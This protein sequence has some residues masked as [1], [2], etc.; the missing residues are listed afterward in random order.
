MNRR[1]RRAAG[2]V[3][4]PPKAASADPAPLY[5]AGIAHL[6]A[7]RM[8]DAQVCGQQALTAD[9]AHAD[10]T[11]LMS[12]ITI[13][14]EHFD[15]A[16]EW[17]RRAVAQDPKPQYLFTLGSVLRQQKQFEEALAA[18]EQATRRKPEVADLWRPVA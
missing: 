12:L 1:E 2:K 7:G 18:F 3:P 4:A 9:P 11:H 16:V 17:A 10:S 14:G 15:L 13:A 5:E 6:R 8:L